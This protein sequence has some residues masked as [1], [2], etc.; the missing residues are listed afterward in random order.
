MDISPH[1][2]RDAV[3]GVHH[4]GKAMQVDDLL[5]SPGVDAQRRELL[6]FIAH[7]DNHIRLIE[8]EADLWS[9]V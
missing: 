4:R 5:V 1:L 7:A 9:P 3:I 6:Q 2:H 8:A